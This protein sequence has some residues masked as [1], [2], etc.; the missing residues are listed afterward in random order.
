MIKTLLLNTLLA[1]SSALAQGTPEQREHFER[2]ARGFA[3]NVIMA[4]DSVLEECGT[5]QAQILDIITTNTPEALQCRVNTIEGETV[6]DQPRTG[7]FGYQDGELTSLGG[8][9]VMVTNGKPDKRTLCREPVKLDENGRFHPSQP[10]LVIT[11]GTPLLINTNPCHHKPPEESG[12][13]VVDLKVEPGEIKLTEGNS[14][15]GPFKRYDPIGT[16]TGKN[17]WVQISDLISDVTSWDGRY[18]DL[19]MEELSYQACSAN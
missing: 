7:V 11:C 5:S 9:T 1:Q 2:Q 10:L 15:H 19:T 14:I 12:V 16:F 13:T 17:G 18:R 8:K 4:P 6:I 3:L